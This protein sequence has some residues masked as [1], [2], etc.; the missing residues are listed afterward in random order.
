LFALA[1]AGARRLGPEFVGDEE[2]DVATRFYADYTAQERSPA[3]DRT[4]PIRH[5]TLSAASRSPD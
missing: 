5:E 4:L 3:D 2:L 1:L